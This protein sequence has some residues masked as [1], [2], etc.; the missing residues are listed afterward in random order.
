M[1]GS[2]SR[3]AAA[4]KES[5]VSRR[6]LWVSV[7][8][9]VVVAAAVLAI[10]LL[11][12]GSSTEKSSWSAAAGGFYHTV[13]LKKDGSLWTWGYNAIGELGLGDTVN[14]YDPTRVSGK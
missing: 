9:A 3:G 10:V 8:V 11:I 6:V 5:R 7:A 13:A 12:G 2:S 4:A 1:A 14:R